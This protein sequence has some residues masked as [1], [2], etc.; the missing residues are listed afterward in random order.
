MQMLIAKSK[1]KRSDVAISFAVFLGLVGSI[2]G[3]PLADPL[4]AL[5]VSGIIVRQVSLSS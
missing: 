3:Y 4:A 2:N 1:L 5:L